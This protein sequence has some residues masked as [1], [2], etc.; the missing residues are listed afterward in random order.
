MLISERFSRPVAHALLLA[1]LAMPGSASA[2]DVKETPP[3]PVEKGTLFKSVGDS[4]KAGIRALSNGDPGSAVEPLTFAAR[5]GNVAA[6]WKLGRMYAEGEGVRRDDY[7]AYQNFSQIVQLRPDESPDSPNARMV[8]QAFVALGTY[9][10]SGIPNTRVRRDPARASEMFHYAASYYNNADAQYH[11]G[12]ILAEGLNGPK[13]LQ[14]AARWFNLAAE[15][16]HCHA[17]A[18][19]GQLLFNGDGVPKQAARGLMWMQLAARQA[20]LAR[21]AWVIELNEAAREIASEDERKLAE[22]YLKKRLRAGQ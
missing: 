14:Q 9:H 22:S 11:L 10:L 13:D 12:R 19:L 7:K 16:G 17:Q 6:Q 2:F 1:V 3:Q 20:D 21:E 8:A 4:L 15:Q 5:E 18:R